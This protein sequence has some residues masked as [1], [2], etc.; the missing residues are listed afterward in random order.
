MVKKH[1]YKIVAFIVFAV[2]LVTIF[3]I[4]KNDVFKNN[5]SDNEEIVN[6]D[7]IN[8]RLLDISELNTADYVC[9]SIQ[10]FSDNIKFMDFDVPLTNK[11]FILSYEGSVKAGIKDFSKVKTE[12]DEDEII[13]TLPKVEITEVA[14]D[15]NSFEIL[16]ETNNIFNPI[17]VQ[18]VNEAQ[19]DLE[20]NI[21][22]A[23]LKYGILDRAEDNAEQIV[24]NMLLSVS[25]DYDVI[26]RWE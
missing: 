24:R 7:V 25:E 14:I 15:L 23:A 17:K 12:V 10:K 9:R 3:F 8:E 4:V 5:V 20:E 19:V 26:I 1:I 18:D 16:E 22:E 2:L 11:G 6:L 13:V 21:K